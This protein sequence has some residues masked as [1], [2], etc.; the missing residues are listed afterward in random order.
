MASTRQLAAI[1]CTDIDGY[2]DLIQQ[3]DSLAI[4]LKERHREV[5][6]QVVEKFHGKILQNIGHDSLSL[7]SSAVEAVQCAIQMQL[8]FREGTPVPVKIGIHLGDII[9]TE[10][11][12]IGDGIIVARKIET[13]ALPGGILISNKIYE[14]VKNQSGIETRYLKTCELVDQGQRVEVYAIANEGIAVPES[15]QNEGALVTSDQKSGSG[16]GHLW[17]EAKRRNVIRVIVM[18]AGAAY[19]IIELVN[20]VVN[21]LSL[22]QW[23]PT[24]V[25]LLLIA[26]FPVTAILSW[27]FDFTPEGIK[28]TKPAGE[29]ELFAKEVQPASDVNWFRRKKVLRRYLVPLFVLALLISFYFLKDSFF[30]NWER[31]NK[32]ALEHTEKANLYLNNQADPELIKRELDLALDAD[33]EYDSAL[34]AYALVHRLEGDTLLAKQKLH[35]VLKSDPGYSN[36]WDLL[37]S[38]AFRQDSFD[39]AMGYAI[40]AMEADPGNYFAAYNL[41]C[42]SEDRGLYDQAVSYF[43]ISTQMDSTFTPGYSA[44]GSLY[45]KMNRPTEAILTLRK[46]LRISPAS[47]DNY[48]VYKNLAE[49]HFLLREYDKALNFLEQSKELMPDY[50]ETE[51]CY[52]RYYEA[53]GETESAVLHWRKYLGLETDSMEQLNAQH[54]LDSLR[55]QLLK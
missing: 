40:M 29:F 47:M 27:I 48:M 10:E 51:K 43:R 16:I 9:F 20:N 4:D 50:A 14:E 38:F 1:L 36:A 19:V 37:A 34:Y 55:Q 25:I 35:K 6:H 17:E 22:P 2:A 53:T 8:V 31:V 52:A 13:Q 39:L 28:K 21:P 24:I 18:Y 3:D 33:P 11:E 30:Q 46:S 49:A 23:L 54:H 45:N 12:A 15:A 26:G 42:Q 44:L 7:F 5:L 32:V 41:A